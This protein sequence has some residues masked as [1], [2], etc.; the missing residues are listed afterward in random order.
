MKI[1]KTIQLS[2]FLFFP[3]ID[4]KT[5]LINNQFE[6]LS[7]ESFTHFLNLMTLLLYN[8]KED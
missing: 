7:I 1:F 8:K 3:E 6:D 2:S 4:Q 5:N